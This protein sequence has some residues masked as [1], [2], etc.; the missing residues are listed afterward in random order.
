M[1][2]SVL[3]ASAAFCLLAGAGFAGQVQ[4]GRTGELQV[5]GIPPRMAP[6]TN[7]VFSKLVFALN[8]KPDMDLRPTA[9][10]EQLQVKAQGNRNT[11]SV[12]AI[13]FCHEFM[14]ATQGGLGMGADFSEE[15]LN[16]VKNLANNTKTDGGFFSLI[17]KGYQQY[18]CYMLGL[19]P[20]KPV[21][22]PNLKVDQA[23]IDVAKKWKRLKADFIKPWDASKGA[24]QAQ[25]DKACDYLK[26]NIPVAAGFLWP[27]SLSFGKVVDLPIMDVPPNKGGV[28]D[29][30]SVALVGFK[31]SALFPGGGYFII[32]NSWGKDWGDEG[33]AYMPFDYVLK[34]CNDL[35]A[36]RF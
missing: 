3:P 11:C 9:K 32:R 33:Y 18:G 5:R 1:L 8:T 10:Q 4:R 2:K 17:D 14:F 30:H 13:T 15:Y 20:Y 36:Y 35:V 27:N 6:K 16:Y 22:D 19:V 12:F 23:Y 7:H 24:S 25:I 31:K 29:G 34:Y 28:Y 26:Q 21:F